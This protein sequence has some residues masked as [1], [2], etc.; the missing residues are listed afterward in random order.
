[1]AYVIDIRLEVNDFELQSRLDVQFQTYTLRK[2][3]KLHIIEQW[4]K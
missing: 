3:L 1:M 4:V 2:L